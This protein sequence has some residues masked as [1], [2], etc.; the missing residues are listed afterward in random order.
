MEF[1]KAIVDFMTISPAAAALGIVA[2]GLIVLAEAT[3]R[4]VYTF[5]KDVY[6]LGKWLY[7][8]SRVECTLEFAK[9]WQLAWEIFIRVFGIIAIIFFSQVFYH[10][11]HL[12]VNG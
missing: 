2:T 8:R 11:Y 1:L 6:T 9:G 7:Y 3:G 12:V 10:F 5:A 4:I